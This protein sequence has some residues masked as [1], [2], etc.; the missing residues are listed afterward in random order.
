M[1]LL[2]QDTTRNGWEFS[3]PEF[4][5]GDDKEYEVKAI[6]DNTVYAKEVDGYLLGL[7]Y[8][9][10]WKGYLEE[11]NTWKSSLAVINLHKIVSTFH[12]DQLEKPKVT[13]V[14]LDSAPPI[15]RPTVKPT[16]LLKQKKGRPIKRAKKR[17][18]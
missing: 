10:A 2:E 15:A 6:Q 13:S 5:P 11:E 16:D 8:L 18:K 1:S 4:K 12:K 3:V 14:S 7:Y 9:I 17:A